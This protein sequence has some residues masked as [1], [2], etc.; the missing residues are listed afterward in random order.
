MYRAV[1]Q[2]FWES[3][4]VCWVV[5][6]Q[7]TLTVLFDCHHIFCEAVWAIQT[8]SPHGRSV[9]RPNEVTGRCNLRHRTLL[10]PRSWCRAN[11]SNSKLKV[12]FPPFCQGSFSGFVSFLFSL[13]HLLLVPFSS[14][15]FSFFWW[16][17][18]SSL[19][20][21]FTS[22]SLSTPTSETTHR[23]FYS[24]GFPLSLYICLL[25]WVMESHSHPLV[26]CVHLFTPPRVSHDPLQVVMRLPVHRLSW[27]GVF[28]VIIIPILEFSL[29]CS[30][31]LLISWGIFSL[32][33]TN[34]QKWD[35]QRLQCLV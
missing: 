3:R 21:R 32:F 10:R 2:V 34:L 14:M 5:V 16:F 22:D 30:R 25:G 33:Q 6:I 20:A 31:S 4:L 19:Q 29:L 18:L 28:H 7:G 8:V 27:P 11:K 17:E 1:S 35:S 23:S 24:L 26:F 15:F 12:V 9:I 13:F